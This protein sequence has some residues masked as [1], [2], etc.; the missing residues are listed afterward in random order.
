VT[1]F[2]FFAI[3]PAEFDREKASIMHKQKKKSGK[4]LLPNRSDYPKSRL[5]DF[6]YRKE[7]AN[8]PRKENKAD[9]RPAP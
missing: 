2:I 1:N 7:I 6:Y 3:F 4:T 5:K 8:T 9:E